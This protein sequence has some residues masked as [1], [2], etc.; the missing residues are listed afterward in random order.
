MQLSWP[1]HHCNERFWSQRWPQAEEGSESCKHFSLTARVDQSNSDSPSCS[2]G[3]AEEKQAAVT[4]EVWSPPTLTSERGPLRDTGCDSRL[5]GE[6][7]L[8]R[9]GSWSLQPNTWLNRHMEVWEERERV[10]QIQ[11]LT[12]MRR[13]KVLCSQ[14]LSDRLSITSCHKS[15]S[16]LM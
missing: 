11:S 4:G 15:A 5:R 8:T 13:E 10:T 2:W 1:G 12:H 7:P 16:F 9:R 3:Q 14:D 6:K